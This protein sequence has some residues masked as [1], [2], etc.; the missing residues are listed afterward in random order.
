VVR[1]LEIVGEAAKA[2]PEEVRAMA[3]SIPWRQIATMRNK[4]IHHYFGVDLEIV[5]GT[6][7]EDVPTL[8]KELETLI[9]KLAAN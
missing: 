8:I 2:V 6:V 3:P 7:V 9:Q 4:L 1:A 5:W